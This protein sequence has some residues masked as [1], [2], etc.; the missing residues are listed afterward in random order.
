MNTNLFR[1]S[2]FRLW[3]K[4]SQNYRAFEDYTLWRLGCWC[5]YLRVHFEWMEVVIVLITVS[6]MSLLNKLALFEESQREFRALS[7][8]SSLPVARSS[9][10]SDELCAFPG[11]NFCLQYE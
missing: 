4:Y 5:A 10:I 7:R 6:K 8:G 1:L 11:V 9:F 3:R 2:S